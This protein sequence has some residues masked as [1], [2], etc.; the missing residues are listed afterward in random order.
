MA[1]RHRHGRNGKHSTPRAGSGG[2]GAIARTST[3][4]VSSIST[5]PVTARSIPRERKHH[6]AA[7][8]LSFNFHRGGDRLAVGGCDAAAA[9]VLP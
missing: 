1:E 6:D 3:F 2:A 4:H 8:A 9:R 7:A 5:T